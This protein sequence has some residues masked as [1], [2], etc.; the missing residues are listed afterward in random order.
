MTAVFTVHLTCECGCNHLVDHG[1]H[2]SFPDRPAEQTAK[3]VREDA[4]AKGWETLRH[5][6]GRDVCPPCRIA[7]IR[8]VS[9]LT[10]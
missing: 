4:A 10:Q 7:E 9:G 5:T 1:C 2:V 8:T 6:K 3:G